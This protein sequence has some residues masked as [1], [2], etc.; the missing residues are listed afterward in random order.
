[1]VVA[2]ARAP[3]YCAFPAAEHRSVTRHA[4]MGGIVTQVRHDRSLAGA[5]RKLGGDSEALTEPRAQ[6]SG[7]RDELGLRPVAPDGVSE[8]TLCVTCRK[9]CRC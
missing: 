5:A 7:P 9:A 1:M 6:A 3:A 2:Q 4:R 8:M